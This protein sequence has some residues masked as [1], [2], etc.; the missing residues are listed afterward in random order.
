MEYYIKGEAVVPGFLEASMLL[1]EDTCG[2]DLRENPPKSS[3]EQWV[4]DPG[5]WGGDGIWKW[6]AASVNAWCCGEWPRQNCFSSCM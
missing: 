2:R 4:V 1:V 5:R 3:P 6:Q